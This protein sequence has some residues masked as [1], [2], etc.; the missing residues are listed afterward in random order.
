[1]S[2]S[3]TVNPEG[4]ALTGPMAIGSFSLSVALL[5]GNGSLNSH[6]G[7]AKLE[8]KFLN[9]LVGLLRT[10]LIISIP[11][12]PITI[13]VVVAIAGIILP[14]INFTLCFGASGIL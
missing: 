10:L 5:G 8:N 14:A 12:A 2:L 13:A 11:T 3:Q 7:K 6:S 9:E 4:T 1:M